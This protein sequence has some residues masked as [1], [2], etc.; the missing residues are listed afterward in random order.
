MKSQ[1]RRF[2]DGDEPIETQGSFTVALYHL[3]FKADAGNKDHL[4]KA[5]PD[6]FSQE[7]FE[8]FC[9]SHYNKIITDYEDAKSNFNKHI[10]IYLDTFEPLSDEKEEQILH[11][12]KSLLKQ[13]P[14][15]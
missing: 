14:E 6:F 10:Q 9:G 7:D 11:E 8:F 15:S 13:L 1:F 12:I 2:Y 3:W 5:F 4:L